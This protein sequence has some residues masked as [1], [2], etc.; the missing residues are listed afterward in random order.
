MSPATDATKVDGAK[1]RAAQAAVDV[2]GDGM[3]VGLGTGSTMAFA[4]A[5]LGARVASGLV[6]RA[7]ATSV[8]SERLAADVGIP[9]IGFEDRSSVDI[10]I[11]GADEIDGAFRAIKGG[12]GALMR[13]KIVASAARRMICIVDAD[14]RV[15]RL[16]THPL[17]VEVLPFAR[18]VVAEGIRAL[19]G[20]PTLRERNGAVF[21]TDQANHIL[22]CRFAPF[23]DPATLARQLEAIPGL[24]AHG[25]FLSEIDELYI[26][27]G[28]GVTRQSRRAPVP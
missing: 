2:I 7:V 22:D 21:L 5:S 28:Q 24:L 8:A 4:I 25:L 18:G 13:E 14:K 12:G 11:D 1:A 9:L 15:T 16:G 3:V 17:P 20:I 23:P 6:I 19:G 10:A 26:G 27:D